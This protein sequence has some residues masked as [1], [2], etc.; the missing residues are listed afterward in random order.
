MYNDIIRTA[1]RHLINFEVNKRIIINKQLVSQPRILQSDLSI[2]F[3]KYVDE[4]NAKSF[5]T[6]EMNQ[7]LLG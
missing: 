4:M 6:C 1:I 5:L 3:S 2:S 7:F